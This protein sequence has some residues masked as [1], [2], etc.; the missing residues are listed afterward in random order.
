MIAGSQ[1]ASAADATVS[2]ALATVAS[3]GA[4]D[5]T[6]WRVDA[7]VSGSSTAVSEVVAAA[8]GVFTIPRPQAPLDGIAYLL[9]TS[10]ADPAHPDA[11]PAVLSAVL[12]AGGGVVINE[13][14]TVAMAWAMAQFVSNSGVGGA[15]PGLQN[16]A[17]MSANIADPATGAEGQLLASS[18]NG[19]E[20]STEAEVNSLTA[21]L[22]SCVTAPFADPG[23]YPDGTCSAIVGAGSAAVKTAPVDTVRALSA[24][25][26]NP[27]V[28]PTTLFAIS[29][30]TTL[31]GN[32]PVLAAAPDAWTVVLRFDGDG[33]SLSGPGNFAIDYK[34]NIWVDNNYQYNADVHTPVCGSDKMFEFS[35][36]GQM[37]TYQGGGLSGAGFGVAIDAH[38]GNL[39]ISNFGF[40]APAPGCPEDQ[41]PPHNTTSLFT[42]SGTALSPA[43]GFSM[44]GINWPQGVAV[45]S[46][47]SA[48]IANCNNGTVTQ[49]P[50]GD[51]SRGRAVQAFDSSGQP[52]DIVDNHRALFVTAA[53]GNAVAVLGYDGTVEETLTGGKFLH[54]M[55]VAAAPDGTVWAANSGVLTLPCPTR[56]TAA[57]DAR[58]DAMLATTFSDT[59]VPGPGADF[60]ASVAEI[61]RDGSTVTDYVGGGITVP[62]GIATD[63]NGNVWV[64]N[65]AGKR[66]SAFCGTDPS[67]CPAGV[68]TGDPLSPATTGYYFDGLTRNTGVAIDQSGNVWVTNN[69]QEVPFQTNPGGHQIVAYL[70]L[71]APIAVPTPD[72][73]V[74]PITPA[75][76]SVAGQALA[77]SGS[78]PAPVI[79][80]ALLVLGAGI[81]ITLGRERRRRARA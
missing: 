41:Q 59:G 18:P 43:S 46:S 39:W 56:P 15:A 75:T 37:T 55:G 34:G 26:R 72:A 51:A 38:T 68:G 48:W 63:G 65:F 70:G 2:G 40:A 30:Q 31:S 33:E 9:A 78:D 35:P 50:G 27:G 16:S 14:T 58:F 20:T 6:G 62:W 71:A 64:A 3:P 80:F 12:P 54:P 24:I 23:D 76:P 74:P 7:M 81:G 10:P 25:A 79:A 32:L 60:P 42:S 45:D 11:A 52:F 1:G 57:D 19:A 17:G 36:I 77:A 47:S 8:N 29:Q 67:T 49:Y 44:G 69:W 5:W 66:L 21:A 4:F 73:P 28:S 61:A 13:R 53:N 22:A